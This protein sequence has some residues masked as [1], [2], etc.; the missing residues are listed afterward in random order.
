MLKSSEKR[1]E[2]LLF[3]KRSKNFYPLELERRP[4]QNLVGRMQS[5]AG[6]PAALGA[7]LRARAKPR[8]A[9]GKSFLVRFFKKEHPSSLAL[10]PRTHRSIAALAGV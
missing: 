4:L 2:A 1:K 10:Q 8:C 6:R 5:A 3:E 9:Q 7:A